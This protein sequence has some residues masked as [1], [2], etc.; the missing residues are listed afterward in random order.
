MRVTTWQALAVSVFVLLGLAWLIV[1]PLWLTEA[2]LAFCGTLIVLRDY[3]R[4]RR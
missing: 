4:R 2:P 1:L 3:R